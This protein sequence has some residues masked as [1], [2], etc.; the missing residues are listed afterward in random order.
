[1]VEEGSE[2]L[3]PWGF[4]PYHSFIINLHHLGLKDLRILQQTRAILF[5]SDAALEHG[6]SFSLKVFKETKA[7]S[8]HLLLENRR[9]LKEVFV[10]NRRRKHVTANYSISNG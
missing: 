9:N 7:S 6:R 10:H 5:Y 3:R 2:S 4:T 1:M 8:S